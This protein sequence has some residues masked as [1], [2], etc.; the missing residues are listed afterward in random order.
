MDDRGLPA[1][2]AA[3]GR[4]ATLPPTSPE[5]PAEPA[6]ASPA[7]APSDAAVP[8]PRPGTVPV[9]GPPGAGRWTAVG[10]REAPAIV[11]LHGTRLS[12]TQWWPQLRTLGRRYRCV[13]LDLPGH[14]TRAGEAFSIEAAR[15]AVLEAIDAEAPS[16]PVVLVGLSLG[17]YVAIETAEH[18][19]DRLAG[20]VLAGCSAEPV[21][22]TGWPFRALATILERTPARLLDRFNSAFFR[23]RYRAALAGPIV[24]GGFW[25]SG[26]SVA[27]RLLVG[28]RFLERLGRLWT[29]VLLVNGSLDPVFGPRGDHWAASCRRGRHAVIPRA[30][31]LSNLDR[32]RVFSGLVASFVEEVAAVPE[33]AIPR[34]R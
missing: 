32:P 34:G 24:E 19:P 13:A 28:R 20:L 6:G 9:L 18:A 31:H 16:G 26:G 15:A 7:P 2:G 27:V 5:Q 17:G 22:P 29:P 4:L 25:S 33:D 8:G 30:M 3:R 14:G 21:G 11:F 1:P 23:T 12:R 10:P